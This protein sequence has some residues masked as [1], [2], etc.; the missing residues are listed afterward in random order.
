M[1]EETKENLDEE[2]VIHEAKDVEEISENE[3]EQ[4]LSPVKKF[5]LIGG[6]ILLSLLTIFGYL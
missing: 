6:I 4:G 2:E 1:S 3:E 5:L